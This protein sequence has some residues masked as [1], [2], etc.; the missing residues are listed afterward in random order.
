MYL[1]Y[2]RDARPWHPDLVILALSSDVAGRTMGVY[3]FNMFPSG[4]P[5]AQP[6]FQIKDR[7]PEVVNLP[8]PRLE[9]IDAAKSV[10]DL[11]YIAYDWYF[12]P[13][14]W[15]LP[16]WR[17]LY[18]SYLFRLYATELPAWRNE[19]KGDSLETINH[20]LLVS[21]LRSAESDG[22]A[23]L[24][25]YLPDQTDYEGPRQESKSLKILRTSGIEF[26]DLL[27]CLD[28][29]APDAR[30]IPR[31]HHYSPAGSA[32]IAQCL[33]PEAAK[34]LSASPKR[35]GVIQKAQKG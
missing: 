32:A 16:R 23:V 3:G 12:D 18:H 20:E 7:R 6:R 11:P 8:L 15:D 5:W 1:R 27:P 31:G 26:L 34:K 30:F 9:E 19:K 21:V 35:M 14:R 22:A 24:V 28:A 33:Y 10:T 13:G 4:L 29:V 17:Y 25:A 2:L